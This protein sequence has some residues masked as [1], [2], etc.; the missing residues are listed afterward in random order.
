[1]SI[2]R[3]PLS[4]PKLTELEQTRTSPWM[5]SGCLMLLRSFAGRWLYSPHLFLPLKTG[6]SQLLC[7]YRDYKLRSYTLNAVSY[8]FLKQQKED[9]HHSIISDLQ[10]GT[11]DTRRRL[12][13]YC[14]KDAYLPLLLMDKL[15]LLINYIEYVRPRI[16]AAC[17]LVLWVTVWCG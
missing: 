11:P 4:R 9:V 5:A 6:R 14:L 17:M 12:A 8:H 1:M 15:S 2:Y 3:M 13:T 16:I 10:N 7:M